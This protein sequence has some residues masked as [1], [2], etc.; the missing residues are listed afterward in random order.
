M[1]AYLTIIRALS[2]LHAGTGQGSG[3]IDLPIARER[4]TGLPYLPGSSLKGVLRAHSLEGKREFI[5]G[6][7]DTGS[8][9]S[10]SGAVQIS[11]QRLLL[12]PVRSLA[13]TF[14]W[15]TSPYVLGRLKRDLNDLGF[16]Q[17]VPDVPVNGADLREARVISD[18]AQCRLV[19]LEATRGLYLEELDLTACYDPCVTQWACWLGPLIFPDECIHSFWHEALCARLCVVHDDLFSFLL[20]TATEVAA[21]IRLQETSKTVAQGGLW[22]EEALP[23]ESVL[24]GVALATPR[25]DREMLTEISQELLRIVAHPLSL[26]GK[27]TVGRGLCRVNIPK[28]KEDANAKGDAR[29]A[30]S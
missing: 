7:E 2:S 3:V 16:N 27:A 6:S 25:G 29:N 21:R 18:A 13:G 4:S 20:R 14:A 8:G 23:T 10:S 5:F 19:A 1:T 17:D 30:H 12:L 28:M 22:Y 24:S 15:V 11:D 26:G 9:A